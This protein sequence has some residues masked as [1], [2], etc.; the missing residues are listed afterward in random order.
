MKK[1]L[2]ILTAVLTIFCSSAMAHSGNE[3]FPGF[4]DNFT[5]SLGAGVP[6][7]VSYQGQSGTI[8]NFGTPS[9]QN[10]TCTFTITDNNTWSSDGNVTYIV[11]DTSKKGPYCSISI[12]DGAL[13]PEAT[14]TTECA[15]G[16]APT[17]LMNNKDTYQFSINKE[18]T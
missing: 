14:M 4:Q 16:A 17:Q 6:V 2:G 18:S 5:V 3:Q 8:Y 9:C 13:A 7:A 11:G 10:N 1:T 15:N 12:A